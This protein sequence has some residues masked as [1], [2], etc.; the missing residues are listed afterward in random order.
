MTVVQAAFARPVTVVLAILMGLAAL[1]GSG[2]LCLEAPSTV[3]LVAC[4]LSHL[5]VT[6]LLFAGGTTLL[7]A[8]SVEK[9]LGAWRLVLV[10]ALATA[11]IDATLLTLL[12]HKLTGYTGSSGVGHA[13]AA[14]WALRVAPLNWRGPAVAVLLG[15]VGAEL[16]TGSAAF[17]AGLGNAVPVPEAH[18]VGL[19]VGLLACL[20]FGTGEI[21]QRSAPHWERKPGRLRSR[22]RSRNLSAS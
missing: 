12:G 14:V 16:F 21:S 8:A 20:L 2:G 17:V 4:H 7:L 3:S 22:S 13:L 6:Q 10:I 11:M 5:S 1:V 15:K 9:E 19:A 18:A